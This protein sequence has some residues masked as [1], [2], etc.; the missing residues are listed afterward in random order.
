MKLYAEV[1]YSLMKLFIQHAVQYKYF[2][3][4]R[5]LFGVLV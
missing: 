1:Y 5:N 3:N 4:A 2:N